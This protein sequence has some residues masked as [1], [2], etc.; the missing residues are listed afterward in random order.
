[1]ARPKEEIHLLPNSLAVRGAPPNTVSYSA[2]QKGHDSYSPG[3]HRIEPAFTWGEFARQR[4]QK[5]HAKQKNQTLKQARER[6]AMIGPHSPLS[7]WRE[8]PCDLEVSDLGAASIHSPNQQILHRVLFRIPSV[9]IYIT[10]HHRR[11]HTGHFQSG[12][13][14]RKP[15]V[16]P[17]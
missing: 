9:V 16:K 5:K 7:V 6:L 17:D 14:D 3:N 12:V 15:A 11:H 10:P 1:H 8:H 13:I 4:K 2:T